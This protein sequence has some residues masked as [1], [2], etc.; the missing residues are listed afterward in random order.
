MKTYNFASFAKVFET[1]MEH[2]NMTKLVQTLFEP[3]VSQKFVVNSR[4]NTYSITPR[5]A[6]DW[7]K[8][9]RDIPKNIKKAAKDPRI[10][11]HIESYF[12]D[13]SIQELINPIKET[14]MH[15]EL[16]SL[17]MDSDLS[18][19]DKSDFEKIYAD[20]NYE[21]FLGKAFLHA[22][23]AD[24]LKHDVKTEYLDSDIDNDI[25]LLETFIHKHPKPKPIEPPEII[26]HG[27]MRYVNELYLVYAEKT[28]TTFNT[29]N[30]LIKYKKL[31]ADFI[32]QRKNY[33]LAETVHR[34]LRDTMCLSETSSFDYMKDEIYE[35]IITTV[36]MDYNS[37]FDRLN[38]VMEHVTTVQLSNNTA[39]M[40]LNWI[41]P[42]EKKGVCHMLVNDGRIHWTG[43]I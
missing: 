4:G 40:L 34:G 33:Y 30:D 28:G 16:I 7:Y 37:G 20:A 13:T 31:Q 5:E 35:G 2:Q 19:D 15:E 12:A 8:Q 14:K 23:V 21:L 25:L 43:D 32:R 22:I 41:G 39:S 27:E 10:Y 26:A 18:K 6:S 38:K 36:E 29:P 1:A 17:I 3:I 24:N 11:N 9:R 42:G